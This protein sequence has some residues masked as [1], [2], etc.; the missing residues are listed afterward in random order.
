MFSL[1]FLRP[2]RSNETA[3]DAGA[4]GPARG[5]AAVVMAAGLR[6][7]FAAA[8][9]SGAAPSLEPVAP[10][11]STEWTAR[12]VVEVQA[13]P[14]RY[15]GSEV[16]VCTF[17][18]GG[19]A[20]ADGSDIRV[21]VRG[22]QL[23]GHRVL[24]VGPGD[25]CRI[26]FAATSGETRYYVYY[27][28]PKAPAPEAWDPPRGLLLEVRRWP[29]GG[30]PDKL[31][32]VQAAWAK[33]QPM[34]ADFV[35]HVSFAF[36]PFGA[37]ETPAIFRY[38]GWFVPPATGSYTI[39]TSSSGGSWVLIDGRPV[40]AWP[41]SHG[42]VGDARHAKPFPLTDA[43]H[44]LEYWNVS[45][46]GSVATVAAWEVPQSGHFVPIPTKAFLPVVEAA[47]IETDLPGER[48]VA[49]F[50]AENVGET[51]WPEQYAVRMQFKNLTKGAALQ[52][53]AKFLW[54]FGDGQ[55]S[56]TVSPTHIYLADGDYTVSL[57]CSRPAD[58]STFRAKVRIERNWR[59][60]TEPG[61]DPI[62]QYADEVAQYDFAKLDLQNLLV[63]V[64]L[65]EHEARG[66][67]LVAVTTE[68]LKRPDL[69]TGDVPRLGLLRAEH[70]CQTGKAAEAVAGLRELED[71]LKSPPTRAQIAVT[72]GEV[73]LKDLRRWDDAEKEFQR[74]LKVYATS[75]ADAMLR[76][77]HIGLGDV[78]RHRGDGDKARQ[79]YRAASAI[80]VVNLPP[81]EAA[82]RVG[83]LARYV[84][85]Y[86]RQSQ[87]EWVTKFLEE[88]AW[89]FPGDKLTGHW[90][91]LKASAL[92]AQGHK[93]AALAE[94]MDVTGA[95]P[96]SPYA[97]RLL[98]LAAECQVALG[99]PDKARL[100]LQTAVEDYPED[101]D[102]A[103]AR[104][105]LM[106]LGGPAGE[107]K[108]K[109]P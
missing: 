32:Q 70:L 69:A 37:S 52:G 46:G 77:A 31:E 95:N 57:K 90:S 67:P 96:Q 86:T 85:D 58:S 29:G 12:R 76:R 55:T 36:N 9:A 45:P 16:A 40:V 4:L 99:A 43:P 107:P 44:K 65:F 97:V 24:Q 64:S 15:A 56:A 14:T 102:Q 49:D 35:S 17:F 105:R 94:A 48:L 89:E 104:T 28:N 66:A 93:A 18:H 98:M 108:P 53:S 91:C 19:L 78:W 20:K 100:L 1:R 7:L 25:L 88:W 23:V 38:T 79:A 21:A 39:A 30:Q 74:V 60:Q 101:P 51:W 84:E 81:N 54:D 83:T 71:R 109:K 103:K 34:G 92:V 87:W 8:A 72:A 73:L 68:L 11:L 26:A 22:R 5:A 63:A 106:A 62:R 42:P 6:L 61:L 41:G 47:L 75:G 27:G 59:K 3:A 82:V 2:L 10:W 50:F 80:K 13:Q 33:A